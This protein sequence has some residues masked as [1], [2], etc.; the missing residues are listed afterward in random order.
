M[1]LICAFLHKKSMD[2]YFAASENELD[3][4]WG[5]ESVFKKR[6]DTLDTSN[7][8]EIACGRGRHVNKY[9]DISDSITLV[10]ILQENINI[11]RKRFGDNEKIMYY[12]NNG[13]NLEKVPDESIS[14]VFSYDSMVHFEMLDIYSYLKDIFRILIPGGKALIHHS[15]NSKDYKA[16]FANAS[17]GRAFMSKNLFA[18]LAY[19]VGFKVLSQDLVDWEIKELDCLTLIEKPNLNE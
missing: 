17:N 4:F 16:S 13:F 3:V 10:D 9:W 18:H 6:F 2:E 5:A 1:Y 15:N 19:K 12:C 8:L 7:I 14:S 11:C